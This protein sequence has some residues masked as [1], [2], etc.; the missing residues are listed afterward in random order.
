MRLLQVRHEDKFALY[1]LGPENEHFRFFTLKEPLMERTLSQL[2]D[3]L[4]IAWECTYP[5]LLQHRMENTVY[6]ELRDD[7]QQ[8]FFQSLDQ[9]LTDEQLRVM[10]ECVDLIS[11]L[12]ANEIL[13]EWEEE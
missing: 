1:W 5:R 10:E 12:Y 7:D 13:E 4:E 8:V 3:M 6:L 9:P 11:E 2:E